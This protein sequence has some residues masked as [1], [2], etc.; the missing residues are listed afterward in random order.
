MLAAKVASRGAEEEKAPEPMDVP[1]RA[2]LERLVEGKPKAE[3][4]ALLRKLNLDNEDT[5]AH[6]FGQKDP[7][8]SGAGALPDVR[9]KSLKFFFNTL[10]DADL[11]H[12]SLDE[13]IHAVNAVNARLGVDQRVGPCAY[14]ARRIGTLR[15]AGCQT[16]Y[17]GK[18]CQRLHW[19]AH[20]PACGARAA[21]QS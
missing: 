8:L 18:A 6:V 1:P 15:C 16:R 12:L 2:E 9:L 14:C 10:V 17:C 21:P 5:V 11:A 4:E 3:V 13:M 19:R 7:R 20:K